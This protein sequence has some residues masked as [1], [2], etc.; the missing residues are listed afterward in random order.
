MQW[1]AQ[2]EVRFPVLVGV[3][4]HL[5]VVISVFLQIARINILAQHGQNASIGQFSTGTPDVT[6]ADLMNAFNPAID[7][8]MAHGGILAVH[9][10]SSPTLQ[11]CF[12][13]SSGEGWFT[14]RYRKWYGM[15]PL[16][17]DWASLSND[18][19]CSGTANS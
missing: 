13:P 11:G 18:M 10:Y 4:T 12:D 1:Y 2:F 5:P 3:W 9:E 17:Q 6:N 7:A 16:F 8:A 19:V 15:V 14:M